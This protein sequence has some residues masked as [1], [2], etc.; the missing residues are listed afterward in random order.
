[1]RWVAGIL[2]AAGLSFL[3]VGAFALNPETSRVDFFVTDNRGGFPGVAGG[4]S[5]TAVVREQDGTFAADVDARIDARAI[6]TWSGLRDAQMH[7]DFLH[8]DQYPLL[9]FHGRVVPTGSLAS[10]SIPARVTGQLTIKDTTRDVE[11]PV[12]VIALADSYLVE[13]Q[14][15]VYMKDFGIPIPQF[16]IFVASDPVVVSMKLRFARA[17]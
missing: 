13:G 2:V 3:P 14:F 6:T 11:F 16:F 7:R 4:V 9:T 12:R 5:A 17:P 10:L 8:T 15:S 1:M